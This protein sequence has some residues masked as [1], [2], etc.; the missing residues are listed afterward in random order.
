MFTFVV[1]ASC[2]TFWNIL[3]IANFW[4]IELNLRY[5]VSTRTITCVYVR[6]IDDL[7]ILNRITYKIINVQLKE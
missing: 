7:F 5:F 3:R 2:P 4:K 1:H 6:Q